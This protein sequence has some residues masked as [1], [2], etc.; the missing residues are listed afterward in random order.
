MSGFCECV[1]VA[2][3]SIPESFPL[4]GKVFP[5]GKVPSTSC[6]SLCSAQLPYLRSNYYINWYHKSIDGE[7]YGLVGGC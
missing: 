7:M 4:G 6:W 5:S 3:V 2:L 1:F